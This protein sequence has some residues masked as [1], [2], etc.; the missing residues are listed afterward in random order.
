VCTV[1][2]ISVCIKSSDNGGIAITNSRSHEYCYSFVSRRW[3][4]SDSSCYVQLV[5][6]L[7]KVYAYCY[8]RIAFRSRRSLMMGTAVLQLLYYK[9]LV[10]D[11]PKISIISKYRYLWFIGGYTSHTRILIAGLMRIPLKKLV[12][13]GYTHSSNLWQTIQ[14]YH[15]QTKVTNNNNNKQINTIIFYYDIKYIVQKQPD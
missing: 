8:I 4:R 5:Q 1:D 7:Y 9:S 12:F 6:L 15:H 14:S 3:Q 13:Y 10:M 2:N 11:G